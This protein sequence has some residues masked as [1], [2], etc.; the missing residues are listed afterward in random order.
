VVVENAVY[1]LSSLAQ[2]T[3][4]NKTTLKRE[5]RLG[6]LRVAKRGGKYVTTGKW[7]MQWVE[8]GEVKP[9]NKPLDRQAEAN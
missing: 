5:A 6:R 1:L 8:A 3:P 9:R 2:E 7:L 4:F